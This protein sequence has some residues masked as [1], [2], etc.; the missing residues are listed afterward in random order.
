MFDLLGRPIAAEQGA[1]DRS[2]RRRRRVARVRGP[3][4][5][6]WPYAWQS[7]L[8]EPVMPGTR[9]EALRVGARA[10]GFAL[11]LLG[12]PAA[13]MADGLPVLG[14]D[15]GSEGVAP[16]TSPIRYVTLHAGRGTVVARTGGRARARLHA[17]RRQLHDP[18]GCLRRFGAWGFCRC[19]HARPHPAASEVPARGR[20]SRSLTRG[21][22]GFASSSPS[23]ATSACHSGGG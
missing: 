12:V 10:L 21:G 20:R 15:V 23:M 22:C 2:T 17:P 5:S 9:R 4:A 14:V 18:G 1:A 8:R 19:R 3:R 13:A 16:R 7:T 6:R 11:V